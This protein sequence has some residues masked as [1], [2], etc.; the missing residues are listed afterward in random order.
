MPACHAHHQLEVNCAC[1]HAWPSCAHERTQ[2]CKQA[3]KFAH[4]EFRVHAFSIMFACTIAEYDI[5]IHAG[6]YAPM[7]RRC[8]MYLLAGITPCP[9]P[10]SSPPAPRHAPHTHMQVPCTHL[11][12][13]TFAVAALGVCAPG[14]FAQ[15]VWRQAPQ[16]RQQ[17][18]VHA[19]AHERDNRRR[20]LRRLRRRAMRPRPKQCLHAVH[21]AQ[22][23]LLKAGRAQHARGGCTARGDERRVGAT[24]QARACGR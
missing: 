14:R 8:C 24:R 21:V 15:R 19:R 16:Q 23:S 10:P 12:R 20:Q 9:L 17:R 4:A 11:G 3:R 6:T 1:M 2:L 13:P 22:Q 18:A 5:S 7:L